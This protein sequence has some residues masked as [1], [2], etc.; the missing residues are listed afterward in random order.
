MT[1]ITIDHPRP[2]TVDPREGSRLLTRQERYGLTTVL[3]AAVRDAGKHGS[4]RSWR[5][6]VKDAQRLGISESTLATYCGYARTKETTLERLSQLFGFEGPSEL[7]ALAREV[8]EE[9][10]PGSHNSTTGL[11]EPFTLF[12]YAEEAS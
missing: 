11:V 3:Q 4:K 9:T 6:L 12:T 7:L 10:F 1:T 5:R 2:D 8:A